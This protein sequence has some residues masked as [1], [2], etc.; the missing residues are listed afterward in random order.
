MTARPAMADA[1]P[2]CDGADSHDVGRI[3]PEPVPTTVPTG[4][5][6]EDH[7][8]AER[9]HTGGGVPVA[10]RPPHTARGKDES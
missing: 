6:G 4:R 9:D 8:D 2:S 7:L 10:A 5:T 1:A 3:E